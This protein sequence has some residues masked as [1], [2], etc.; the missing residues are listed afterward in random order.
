MPKRTPILPSAT[1]A[2]EYALKMWLAP[3]A[4]DGNITRN[5]WRAILDFL[6]PRLPVFTVGASCRTPKG[7]VYLFLYERAPFDLSFSKDKFRTYRLSPRAEW[8]H[9]GLSDEEFRASVQITA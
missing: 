3:A 2:D 9:D 1:L 5:Q 4:V 7:V 8:Y 6:S